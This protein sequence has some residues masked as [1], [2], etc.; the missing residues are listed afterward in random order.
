[1][2]LE[3]SPHSGRDQDSTGARD[4]LIGAQTSRSYSAAPALYI[5]AHSGLIAPHGYSLEWRAQLEF[6]AGRVT[7]G[8]HGHASLRLP[9]SGSG[10]FHGHRNG[11]CDTRAVGAV[12]SLLSADV[13][14][15]RILAI[16]CWRSR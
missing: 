3:R 11:A 4:N 7:E 2:D 14:Q 1:M 13:S 15:Y 12:K 8:N 6:R 9:G 10:S 5:A 16:W